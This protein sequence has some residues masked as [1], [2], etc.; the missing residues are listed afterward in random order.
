MRL[1]IT[2]IVGYVLLLNASLAFSQRHTLHI[3]ELAISYVNGPSSVTFNMIS[4]SSK[5]WKPTQS[6]VYSSYLTTDKKYVDPGDTTISGNYV[7]GGW[8]SDNYP[9][10]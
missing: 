10:N 1:R 2:S 5:V 4:T 7:S 3:Y 8:N 9:Y 6:F